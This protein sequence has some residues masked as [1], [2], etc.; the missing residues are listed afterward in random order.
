ML[1]AQRTVRARALVF[2]LITLT[3]LFGLLAGA[4]AA[5]DVNFTISA[6][7]SS[8]TAPGDVTVSIRVVNASGADMTEP[9]S[10]YDP[11]NKLVT[12][13]A[14]GGQALLSKDGYATGKHT[15]KV[16]QAQLDAG[17]LTYTISYNRLDANGVVTVVSQEASAALTF[18]GT[19]AKLT[20]NRTIDPAVVRNGK[21]VTVLYELYNSGNVTLTSIRVQENSSISRSAQ[22]VQ[23][24]EPGT[25]TTVKFTATMG[26]NDLTSA[27][28]VSYKA[29]TQ[30]LKEDLPSVTIPRAKPGLAL[31]NI[32]SADKTS[33]STGETA[34]LTLTIK[35]SGNITYSNITVTDAKYGEIFTNLT[36]APGETLVKEKQFTLSETTAFKFTVTLPDNTGVTTPITSNEVKVSVYDPAQV[37]RITVVATSDKTSVDQIP[38]TVKFNV[39]VTNNSGVAAKN[40][41]LL[42]GKTQ[43]ASIGEIAP[44]QSVTITR[45]FSISQAGKFRFTASAKDALEN[46]VTFDSNEIQLSYAPPTRVPTSVPVPTVAPMVEVT[47]APIEVLEPVTSR[48]AAYLRYAAIGFGV[49]FGAALA[50]FAASTVIRARRRSASENAY[51]HM[52]LVGKRDYTEPAQ[53]APDT[54][55]ISD[56]EPPIVPPPAAVQ[57]EELPSDEILRG[58]DAPAPERP[59]QTDREPV[60]YQPADDSGAYRLTRQTPVETPQE[61][62]AAEAD[63]QPQPAG[64]DAQP[65]ARR[66]RRAS[67]AGDKPS[68]DE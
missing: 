40:V 54:R 50:L 29:G 25:R 36:L 15:Y 35:N 68:E 13:F 51:D 6:E 30:P 9:I 37:L 16:T 56:D 5:D 11:D 58:E 38:A 60:S 3:L 19:N 33:I 55:D 39:V 10:L 4:Q 28:K 31:D 64:Q 46:T 63:A 32:L 67:R 20:V 8:L 21:A 17:K 52:E 34:T 59:A 23:S 27:G 43:I 48:S 45:D 66:H 47:I 41:K 2:A 24:L 26:N 65:A 62:P 18:T 22:T 44:A 53:Y 14:D 12:G 57:K 7:P 42:H 1:F 61:A 49:L